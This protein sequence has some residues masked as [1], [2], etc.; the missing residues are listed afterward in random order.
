MKQVRDHNPAQFVVDLETT[1]P[2]WI[3]ELI[4]FYNDIIIAWAARMSIRLRWHDSKPRT[5][6]GVH[7]G[8]AEALCASSSRSADEKPEVVGAKDDVKYVRPD[9]PMC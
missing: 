1:K 3:V 2:T 9:C 4:V 6:V 7:E 8:H 5:R